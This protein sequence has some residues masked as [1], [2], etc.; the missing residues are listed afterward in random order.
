MCAYKVE[1]KHNITNNVVKSITVTSSRKAA[2][3]KSGLEINLNKN[4]YVTV[5][6]NKE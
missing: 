4:Y 5:S 2:K 6:K 1:V 3:L